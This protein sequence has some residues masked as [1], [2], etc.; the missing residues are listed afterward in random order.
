MIIIDKNISPRM[1]TTTVPKQGTDCS[2][3]KV[4]R[5]NPVYT[6]LEINDDYIII[7]ANTNKHT[8]QTNGRFQ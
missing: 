2:R 4:R 7:A 6:S 1:H 3:S 8:E 5:P